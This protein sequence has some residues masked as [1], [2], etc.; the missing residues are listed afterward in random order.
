MVFRFTYVAK[1]MDQVLHQNRERD[2]DKTNGGESPDGCGLQ[3]ERDIIGCSSL[4]GSH[5]LLVF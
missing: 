3:R 5:G 2:E 4:S 1:E